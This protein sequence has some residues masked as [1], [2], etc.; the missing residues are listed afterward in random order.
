MQ[1]RHINTNDWTKEAIDSTL[2]RGNL[3]DWQ[4]LF[5][6]AIGDLRLARDI[7]E[8]ARKH[9]DDGT[10]AIAENLIKKAHPELF[11]SKI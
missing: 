8:M 4:D 11:A 2:E 6:S 10:F 5:R 1:H 3:E 7:L 9:N